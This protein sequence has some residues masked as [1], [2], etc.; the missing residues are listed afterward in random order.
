MICSKIIHSSNIIP[1]SRFKFFFKF[2]DSGSE[3]DSDINDL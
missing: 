2:L 3:F 1:S